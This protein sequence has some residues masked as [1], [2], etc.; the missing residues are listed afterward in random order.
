MN[1]LH[2]SLIPLITRFEYGH[3]ATLSSV[4]GGSSQ[5]YEF[6]DQCSTSKAKTTIHA[7]S[8]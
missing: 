8:T 5:G 3:S 6:W 1:K 2:I 7:L 4:M